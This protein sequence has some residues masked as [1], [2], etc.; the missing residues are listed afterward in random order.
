MTIILTK[1]APGGETRNTFGL[2]T[3]AA[4]RRELVQVFREQHAAILSYLD[5]S[6]AWDALEFK[7]GMPLA[8]PTWDSLDLGVSNIVGRVK[9]A[10]GSIWEKAGSSFLALLGLDPDGWDPNDPKN[11]A[12]IEQGLKDLATEI[13][14]TTSDQLQ[15]ALDTVSQEVADG[16]LPADQAQA[17]LTKDV[18]EIFGNAE[19]WRAKRIAVTEASRAYHQAIAAAAREFGEVSGWKWVC[20]GDP[21]DICLEIQAECQFM[22]D[23]RPFAII[24]DN[25]T[26]STIDYP[27]AHPNCMCSIEPVLISDEQPDWGQTLIQPSGKKSYA[28]MAVMGVTSSPQ[29]RAFP[30]PVIRQR[31]LSDS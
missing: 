26:Y 16:K 18:S 10:I 23:G 15:K 31:L 11:I 14:Q 24:G 9:D 19:D 5:Q 21:C 4:I 27:P 1:K 3:G 29:P 17:E 6:K 25:P 7:W 13:N 20:N 12:L 2:P 8:W 30:T 22:L 28:P